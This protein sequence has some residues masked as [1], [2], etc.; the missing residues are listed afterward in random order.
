MCLNINLKSPFILM[1]IQ[2]ECDQV[3]LA[4]WLARWL[5]TGGS[6]LGKGDNLLISD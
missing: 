3:V 5:A 2:F 4:Q 6:N 1:D